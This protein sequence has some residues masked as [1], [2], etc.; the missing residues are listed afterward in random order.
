[1]IQADQRRLDARPAFGQPRKREAEKMNAKQPIFMAGS[2]G[3][4]LVL[5]AH[6]PLI[7]TRG[8]E[9]ARSRAPLKRARRHDCGDG[10]S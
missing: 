8:A 2:D 3:A 4:G 9:G 5:A 6:V 10:G 7:Q 1:M